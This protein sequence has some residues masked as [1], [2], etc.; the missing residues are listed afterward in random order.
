MQRRFAFEFFPSWLVIP[1]S[2]SNQMEHLVRSI[3]SVKFAIS[4]SSLNSWLH[5][6]TISNT[7]FQLKL[8]ITAQINQRTW[9]KTEHN[10]KG[11]KNAQSLNILLFFIYHGVLVCFE[12][13]AAVAVAVAVQKQI[14][15]KNCK[16]KKTLAQL[17]YVHSVHPCHFCWN[18]I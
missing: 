2:N 13:V 12:A 18:A 1:S 5:S 15:K 16:A 9:I 14:K 8:Q 10:K 4:W 7:P 6:L 11:E 3:W 17:G